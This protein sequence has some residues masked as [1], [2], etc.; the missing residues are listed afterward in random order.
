MLV[1]QHATVEAMGWMWMGW[2]KEILS[3]EIVRIAGYQVAHEEQ[4]AVCWV[5][6][7]G[8]QCE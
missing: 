5:S 2:M 7:D 8:A 4:L 6:Y 1:Q 3:G